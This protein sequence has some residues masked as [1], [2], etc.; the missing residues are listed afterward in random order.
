MT[1]PS[2]RSQCAKMSHERI[3]KLINIL[4]RTLIMETGTIAVSPDTEALR[5]GGQTVDEPDM[6]RVRIHKGANRMTT[7]AR[8]NDASGIMLEYLHLEF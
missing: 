7:P 3:C 5:L 2:I 4:S 6:G 1:N 8:D